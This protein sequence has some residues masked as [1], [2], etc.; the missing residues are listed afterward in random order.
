MSAKLIFY[1]SLEEVLRLHEVLIE[2]H[3]GTLGLRDSGLLASALHRPQTGYYDTLFEQAASLFQSLAMNHCFVDGNKRVAFGV[4]DAFLRMNG[5]E[6]E[7][8][9]ED[10]EKFIIET[11]I[12][13]KAS[14]N[15]IAIWLEKHSQKL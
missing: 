9:M 4:T 12:A 3:G 6:I 11:I 13:S 14:I 15:D 2:S 5:L 8:T 7:T 1:P 10:A